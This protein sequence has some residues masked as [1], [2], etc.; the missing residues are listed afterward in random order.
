MVFSRKIIFFFRETKLSRDSQLL[1]VL[2]L[3]DHFE[4]CVFLAVFMNLYTLLLIATFVRF[5]KC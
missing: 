4:D 3:V 5:C 2:S 1:S